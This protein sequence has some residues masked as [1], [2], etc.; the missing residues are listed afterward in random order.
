MIAIVTDSTICIPQSEAEALSI[1]IVSNSY[2]V[3]TR[4]YRES[5]SDR[6]GD[7]E[8]RIFASPEACKTGQAPVS[9]FL[10]VFEELVKNGLDVL[11][12]TLSSRL[13][14]TFSSARVAAREVN[15][16]KISVVDSLSTAGGLYLLAKRACALAVRGLPLGE[17]AQAVTKLRERTGIA[18]SVENMAALRR[19]GRLGLVPQSTGTVLNIRPILL[20][21]HGTVVSRGLARGAAGRIREIVDKVP[22]D[23]TEIVV[24]HTGDSAEAEPLVR[25]VK[26]R[27]P[28]LEISTYKLGPVLGVHLGAGTL[29]V[30]WISK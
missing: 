3:G 19:S 30:A 18:F 22:D 5:Y 13:S 20:C 17:V 29:G 26:E 8:A 16:Q 2:S 23:A 21:L 1:R 14:G 25:R 9:A 24:H 28:S 4:V 27:F 11:C 15:A 7:F 10:P 12:L 6:N